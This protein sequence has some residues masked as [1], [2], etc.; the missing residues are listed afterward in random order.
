[1]IARPHKQSFRNPWNQRPLKR[2][3][4]IKELIMLVS[5]ILTVALV[6]SFASTVLAVDVVTYLDSRKSPVRGTITSTTKDSISIQERGEIVKV[7]VTELRAVIFDNE[8]NELRD[9]REALRQE[10]NPARAAEA[11]G[12]IDTNNIERAELKSEIQFFRLL[13]RAKL[14]MGGKEKIQVVGAELSKFL[15]ANP[16]TYH[17]YE[18]TEAVGQLLRA[19]KSYAKAIEYFGKLAASPTHKA[20]A[21]L[22]IGWTQLDQDQPE[23]AQK[24]FDLALASAGSG[25]G[26]EELKR[27]ATL[28]K[29]ACLG[30]AGKTD[31]AVKMAN[32]VIAKADPEERALHARAYNVLGGVH[33][34]AAAKDKEKHANEAVLAFLHV[35]V[36]YPHNSLEHAEALGNLATLWDQ[37]GQPQRANDARAKLRSQYPSSRWATP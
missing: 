28:G 12:R 33:A 10:D 23:D 7:P 30:G 19:N 8:P 3:V 11:L 22:A 17:Y 5:R 20:Q 1:L 29:A 15:D 24:A 35:D 14:A 25:P 16:N 31:D 26:S 2:I 9:A 34:K 27:M 4:R 21:N 36:L 32:E 6:F 13:A 37:V 18:A